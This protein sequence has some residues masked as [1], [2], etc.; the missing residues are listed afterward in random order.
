MVD[1]SLR[2][3]DPVDLHLHTTFSDGTWQPRELFDYVVGQGFRLVAVTDH[4]TLAHLEAARRLA[5]RLGIGV[6]DG[7]EVTASWR[8]LPVHLLCYARDLRA[9]QLGD[10]VQQ[11]EREQFRNTQEVCAEL[12]RRGFSF[13]RQ[14]DVLQGSAGLPVRPIDNARLLLE[15]GYADNLGQALKVITDAGYR[16]ITASL[17]ATVET[18]H[19]DGA[20]TV[21]AHPGRGGGELHRFEPDELEALLADV[22]VDGVEVY[23]PAHSREQIEGYA[24]LVTSRG[25]ISGAGS[26]SHGPSQRLPVAYPAQFVRSLLARCGVR[27]SSGL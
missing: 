14:L 5:Q 9:G 19:A 25:L 27:L 26:D 15:H 22:P 8:G 18:A 6:L 20:V 13:P 4:D 11:T 23:Y 2:D 10:L 12:E 1:L 24:A 16:Q 17:G 3:E 21:I 7:V